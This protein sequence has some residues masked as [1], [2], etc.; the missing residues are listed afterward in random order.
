MLIPVVTDAGQVETYQKQNRILANLNKQLRQ[1]EREKGSGGLPEINLEYSKFKHMYQSYDSAKLTSTIVNLDLEEMSFCLAAALAKHIEHT[2]KNQVI[3]LG[4][5]QAPSQ[6]KE[7]RNAA[8][9]NDLQI[10][11][12]EDECDRGTDRLT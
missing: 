9:K 4:S 6:D 10:I 12:E 8:T 11:R 5:G 7:A 3:L 1:E 2:H